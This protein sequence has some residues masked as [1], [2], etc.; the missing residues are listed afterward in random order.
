MA[1]RFPRLGVA[2][3]AALLAAPPGADAAYRMGISEQVPPM[4]A[5]PAWQSLHLRLT[6]YIVAWDWLQTGQEAEVA[7]FMDAA[8][9]HGQDVLVTFAAHRGCF[10]GVRYSPAPVCRAPSASAYR[11]AVRAFEDR[12]PWVRTY[13]AWNEV[14]HVSQPTFGRPQ[15]A[16][17]YYSVLLR[18]SRRR[19]F[20][21]MAAD[22]LDTSN[23]RG[24]LRAFL[25]LAPGRPRLWGLHNYQD[26]NRVTSGDTREMLA[27][28]PGEVWLTETGAIVKLGN[29]RQFAYSEARAASRTRWMFRLA[30]RLD[31]PR[32]GLRSRL[33][34]LY[35]YKWFGEPPGARFDAGLVGFD[36]TPRPA[37]YVVR[38]FA[39]SHR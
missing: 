9:A 34:R 37:F 29:S 3:L 8:R 21:V 14:N 4:F 36:G 25:R 32:R 12:Y 26:V 39:R 10:D 22:V 27:T 6:R 2:V 33:T 13:S 30:G 16:A 18:E 11:A 5:S 19:H 20:R 15:L 35:V 23:M 7:A 17:R 28:V 1:L 31:S 24:Y 38:R